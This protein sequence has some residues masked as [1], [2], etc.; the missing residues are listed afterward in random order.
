MRMY[1]SST[2]DSL[3]IEGTR[4]LSRSAEGRPILT[5]WKW[6][7]G[8]ADHKHTTP[9]D[10]REDLR[11]RSTTEI[12]GIFLT[13]YCLVACVIAILILTEVTSKFHAKKRLLQYMNSV[14][15]GSLIYRT[16]LDRC[17]PCRIHVVMPLYPDNQKGRW[18]LNSYVISSVIYEL[19]L[20]CALTVPGMGYRTLQ[21]APGDIAH[22]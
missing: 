10:D 9:R 19:S 15:S 17:M 12:F 6:H 2:V 1:S 18:R 7:T 20:Q 11:S 21:C 3:A 13:N 14:F 22:Y 4:D 16:V 8:D 5:S